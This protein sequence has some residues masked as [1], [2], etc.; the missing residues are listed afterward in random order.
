[1][2][3]RRARCSLQVRNYYTTCWRRSPAPCEEQ[4]ILAELHG[5]LR[6]RVLA[7]IGAQARPDIPILQVLIASRGGRGGPA[8]GT[9][10]TGPRSR[11]RGGLRACSR[12]RLTLGEG[13]VEG[14]G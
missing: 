10:L 5:P 11:R 14:L 6:A 8:E 4:R 2:L 9:E 7:Q 12:L 13:V 3:Q 1:M